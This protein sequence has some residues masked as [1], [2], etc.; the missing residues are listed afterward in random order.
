MERR[1]K[2]ADGRDNVRWTAVSVSCVF[3]SSTSRQAFNVRSSEGTDVWAQSSPGSGKRSR[4]VS[5]LRSFFFPPFRLVPIS[6]STNPSVDPRRNAERPPGMGLSN[7][8]SRRRSPFYFAVGS[9]FLGFLSPAARYARRFSPV[10][11]ISTT[12]G[13]SSGIVYAY[14]PCSLL[15]LCRTLR[16]LENIR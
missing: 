3:P 8:T 16:A 12:H 9:S 7:V 13:L 6:T 1:E 15:F 10:F 5:K 4:S 14:S 2:R 11:R